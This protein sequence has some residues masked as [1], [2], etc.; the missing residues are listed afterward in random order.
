MNHTKQLVTALAFA[1]VGSIA[2]Q[3]A[4]IESDLSGNAIDTFDA[5]IS[6]SDLIQAGSATLSGT[7]VASL[8]PSFGAGGPNDGTAT[9]VDGLTYWDISQ[10]HSA[11]ETLTFTLAGSATGYDITSIN[12]IYGWGDS[13][14]RFAYQQWDLLVTTVSNPVFT[15]LTSVLYA[16]F[17]LAEASTAGSSQVTL[18]DSTGKIAS[19]VT[20][21]AFRFYPR[22]GATGEVGVIHELDVLGSASAAAPVP[23]PSAFGMVGMG[24]LALI[25]RRK[26]K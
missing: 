18:T 10:D 16:P 25:T 8:T 19:G 7:Y 1:A 24:M 15:P 17:S 21:L 5:N 23:E 26:R 22:P 20:G 9:V 4:I 2:A 12:S 6:S 3:A 11:G 14:S 13:R